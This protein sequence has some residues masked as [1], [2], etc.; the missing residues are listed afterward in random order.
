MI[1]SLMRTK[2]WKGWKSIMETKE[3]NKKL[4]REMYNVIR[5]E[6]IINIKTQKYDD[7]QMISRIERYIIKKIEEEELQNEN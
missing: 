3:L 6:E 5:G 2:K 4:L 1:I 7:K